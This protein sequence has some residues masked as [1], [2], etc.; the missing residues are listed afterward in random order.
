MVF[1]T[2]YSRQAGE[3]LFGTV[4]P[5]EAW[6]LIEHA[7]R[8]ARGA[9][10]FLSEGAPGA[11][12]R[13]KSRFPTLR[14]GFLRK[15][16]SPSEWL[17]GYLA[18]SRELGSALYSFR[19]RH[20]EDVDHI[21]WD[22]VQ[23]NE[24]LTEPLILVCTHGTHDLCCAKFGLAT[25][26]A[27]CAAIRPLCGVSVWQTSHV[28]GCRFAPNVVVLPQGIIY[29][30]VRVE[31]CVALAASI[32]SGRVLTGL[33]RGRSCY[34]KPMQAAE[35]FLREQLR[36]TGN[37]RL[38]TSVERPGGEW[39]VAFQRET[40]NAI[41]RLGTARSAIRTFKSCSTSELSPRGEFHL[42]ECRPESG[43]P[44][45]IREESAKALASSAR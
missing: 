35:Y 23:R 33:L 9:G 14:A 15:N 3:Q 43:G 2:D 11:I 6:L 21:D 42:I 27:M 45:E 5:T 37:L 44:W 41:V 24:P 4:T 12:G 30:R 18:I 36:E 34:S 31:D 39:T 28:G 32:R 20:I 1:C 40:G 22:V 10:D 13:L 25:H 29:G 26:E 8:W 38:L 16:R 19:F 7:E 17:T